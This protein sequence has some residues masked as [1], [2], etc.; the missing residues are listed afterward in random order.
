MK[1]MLLI[2]QGTTPLP[3]TERAEGPFFSPDG[4]W[5]G[6][7]ARGGIMKVRLSGGVPLLV[8]ATASS[9]RGGASGARSNGARPPTRAASTRRP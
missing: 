4:E 9:A 1:Y 5:L 6:F 7:F 8:T 3:G 2:Y